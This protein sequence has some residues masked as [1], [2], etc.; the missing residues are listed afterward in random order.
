MTD[1]DWHT[2]QQDVL[3]V[4]D[5]D[6]LDGPH[7]ERLIGDELVATRASGGSTRRRTCA[8]TARGAAAAER[9]RAAV[10]DR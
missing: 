1:E 4:L 8:A 5:P 7:A 10:A 9:A 2:V 6:D 3:L